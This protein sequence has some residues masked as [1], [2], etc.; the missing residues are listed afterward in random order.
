[1]HP[2]MF[3]MRPCFPLDVPVSCQFGEAANIKLWLF[4]PCHVALLIHIDAACWFICLSVTERYT[5][6]ILHAAGEL[7]Q[8]VWRMLRLCCLSVTC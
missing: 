5:Y 7:L 2:C 8:Y 6:S 1:M 3:D 4:S